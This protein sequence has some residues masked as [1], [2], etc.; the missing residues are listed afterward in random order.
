MFDFAEFTGIS[1]NEF[2]SEF[3]LVEPMLDKKWKLKE[4]GHL[5]YIHI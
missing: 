3:T 1:H 5:K 2:L 4:I